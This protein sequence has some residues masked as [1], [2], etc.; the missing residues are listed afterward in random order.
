MNTVL[1]KRFLL[2]GTISGNS[3]LKEEC[4]PV[5]FSMWGAGPANLES[6]EGPE[7]RAVA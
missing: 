2:T 3:G 1:V 7:S 4:A 6:F 5:V